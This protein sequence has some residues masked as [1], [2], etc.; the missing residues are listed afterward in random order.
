M[1]DP[2]SLS[3]SSIVTGTANALECIIVVQ[4]TNVALLNSRNEGVVC[5]S[6]LPWKNFAS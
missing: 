3:T 6:S 5:G 4:M 2:Q 1:D